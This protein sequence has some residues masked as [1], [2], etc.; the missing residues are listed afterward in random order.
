MQHLTVRCAHVANLRAT[1]WAVNGVGRNYS[2]AFGYGIMDATCMV[3]VLFSFLN[4]S[5]IVIIF[6]Q[7][8][9]A[10]LWPSISEQQKCA[11]QAD[12]LDLIIPGKSVSKASIQVALK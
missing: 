11:R 7:V 3:R 10:K 9:T 12:G 2:H 1:D 4:C 8:R 6:L 5:L